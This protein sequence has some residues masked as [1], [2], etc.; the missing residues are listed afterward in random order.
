MPLNHNHPSIHPSTFPLK[1]NHA[2]K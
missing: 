1:K 2:R